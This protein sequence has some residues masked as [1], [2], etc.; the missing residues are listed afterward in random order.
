MSKPRIAVVGAGPSGCAVLKAFE[1][2]GELD[3]YEFV[4]FEK[5]NQL[6]GLWNFDWH[7]GIND[8]GETVHNSMYKYLWSNGPKEN[9]EFPDFPMS[10]HFGKP[11]PS[12]PPRPVMEKY[13]RA[14]YE[15]PEFLKRIRFQTPVRWITYENDKFTVSSTDL[16]TQEDAVE[17]F[18]YLFV[19]SGHYSN[20]NMI[21]NPGFEKFEGRLMH[22]HDFRDGSQFK[23]K[24]VVTIGSSYSAE[25]IASQ[26]VK[27]GAKTAYLAARQKDPNTAWYNYDW[28]DKFV[29][30]PN[31]VKTEG[32]TV[33]FE[34]GSSVVADAV[35][36]CT[37][38][39]HYYPFLEQKLRLK[40]ADVMYPSGLY[41][42]IFW[43]K[44]PK[45]M[46]LGAQHQ[47]FTY[48][49]FESQAWYARDVILGKVP[50]PNETDR[51]TDMKKWKALEAEIPSELATIQFQADMIKD[52]NKASN[53][54]DYDVDLA[55]DNF[56]EFVGNKCKPDGIMKFRDQAHVDLVTK[57]RS[58][59][60]TNGTWFERLDDT[61]ET[62]IANC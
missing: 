53:Y 27:Y 43:H 6:G 7:T 11:L 33:F 34:D 46:Y 35:I 29:M 10:K 16:K 5:M 44:N 59:L 20:P 36:C 12:Y 15:K 62:F 52:L 41:K 57:Q 13:L 37:G 23:D 25:D 14:R 4:V 47:W 60:P 32:S 56:R 21:H 48:T 58:P 55:A 8:V 39:N 2:A 51:E 9:L 50:L 30:K 17:Q 28:S 3:N 1:T 19:C 54:F 38:Y 24:I 18:D 22:A 61:V 26:C 45:A 31:V 49:Q 40:T 42:G